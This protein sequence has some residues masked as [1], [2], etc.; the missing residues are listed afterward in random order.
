MVDPASLHNYR[1]DAAHSWRETYEGGE[2]VAE[3]VL[4]RARQ[5]SNGF[6]LHGGHVHGIEISA[7]EQA[8]EL[9]GVPAVVLDPITRTLRYEGGSNDA[10]VQ[11]LVGEVPVQNI[12]AGSGLVSEHQDRGAAVEPTNQRVHVAL[13]C[14]N[15]A[16]E[17]WRRGV[18]ARGKSD[19][20]AVLVDVQADKK[21]SRLS[22]G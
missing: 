19:A 9:D 22:H 10:T 4:P 5:V 2:L 18:P 6:V 13:A 12:A 16:E 14:A 7:A 11:A 17:V 20:N 3:R 15:L 21:W 8:S 1:L